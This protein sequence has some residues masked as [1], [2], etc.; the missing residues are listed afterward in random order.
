MLITF[1]LRF[2]NIYWPYRLVKLVRLLSKT[3]IRTFIILK[4]ILAY[5]FPFRL[6]SKNWIWLKHDKYSAPSTN[7]SKRKIDWNSS[8][9]YFKW[10]MAFQSLHAPKMENQCDKKI[11]NWKYLFVSGNFV[12]VYVCV[13]VLFSY[14]YVHAQI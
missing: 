6:C 13:F 14:S 1:T 10:R 5:F 9:R 11:N 7:T 2:T 3:V 12:S 8:N 4:N